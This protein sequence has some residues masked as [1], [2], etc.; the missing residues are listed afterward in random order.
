ML[1]PT[2][3]FNLGLKYE[4]RKE[5]ATAMHYYSRII[6][7]YPQEIAPYHRLSVLA[8]ESGDPGMALAWLEKG[9]AVNEAVAELWNN[10]ALAFAELKQYDEAEVAFRRAFALRPD[11]WEA[12]YNFGRMR[13]MQK[14]FAEAE[15]LLRKAA[16]L[17]P[18]SPGTFNNLGLALHGLHRY[19]EACVA[20]D[21]TLELEPRYVEARANKGASLYFAHRFTEAEAQF[22]QAITLTPD[23]AGAHYNLASLLLSRGD[24][25]Q[26]FQEYEWRWKT[27]DWP[28][29]RNYNT[30]PLWEGEPLDGQTI[31]I[32]HEQGIGDTIQFFRLLNDLAKMNC[33]IEVEV[34]PELHRLFIASTSMPNVRFH[35]SGEGVPPFDVHAPF[36]SLPRL[37]GIKYEAFPPFKPYLRPRGFEIED[38][39]RKLKALTP[40]KSRKKKR[41]GIVWAGNPKHP[42]DHLR[43]MS[44]EIIKPIV[45]G[46]R[47]RFQFFSLQPGSGAE[48]PHV[49]NL[50]AE[51]KDF[52]VT[53]GIV[54]NL[55][56]VIAVDTSIVHLTGALG[57]RVWTMLSHTPDWRWVIGEERT[58]WYPSMS[59]FWQKTP[60]AWEDV[61][62]EV[63]ETLGLD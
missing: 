63:S 34:Q 51:L 32:W 8:L 26:G 11:N 3:F 43:S 36:M 17:D 40:E 23:E 58:K 20:F 56:L 7:L 47:D 49:I 12:Y 50:G 42:S 22:R 2:E 28:A 60:G 19:D 55:D 24:L 39:R 13:L 15:P 45:S 31:F 6:A 52:G 57:K 4:E 53:A 44:W 41:I 35:R 21:R 33:E 46:H 61:I 38:W 27:K 48:S 1:T 16:E 9:I 5:L 59:L 54:A 30:R 25:V 62:T 10:R 29:I 18:R 14:L 37:L